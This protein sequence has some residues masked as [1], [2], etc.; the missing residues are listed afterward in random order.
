MIQTKE[1]NILLQDI[2]FEYPVFEAKIYLHYTPVTLRRKELQ[3]SAG[4]T[5]K[6][7]FIP[8]SG[9]TETHT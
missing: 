6:Q 1:V 7:S 5:V 4:V 2:L 8:G 3:Q 9:K